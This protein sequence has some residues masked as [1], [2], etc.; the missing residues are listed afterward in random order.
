[1]RI[2]REGAVTEYLTEAL[3]QL[4]IKKPFEDI[5]VTDLCNRAGVTRM[6][7]Y[8]NF[9]SKEEILRQW[10]TTITDDFLEESGISFKNDPLPVYFQ[11]LFTH[12]QKHFDIC[13]SIHRAGMLHIVKDEFDRVFLSIHE[14]DYDEYKSYFL[15]GGVYNVFLLWL[16]TG[17]RET[18]E[19][20]AMKLKNL[21]ER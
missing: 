1:M 18:P 9:D 10:I 13:L 8:R 4:M 19:Q 3:L 5:S 11:K 6:S 17:G 15:A 20:L 21:L 14:G 12:L 2:A 7:F 16:I